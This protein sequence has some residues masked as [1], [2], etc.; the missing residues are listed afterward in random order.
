MKRAAVAAFA[1]LLLVGAGVCL[2]PD[3]ASETAE[4]QATADAHLPPKTPTI[5]RKPV[6]IPVAPV[7]ASASLSG[8]VHRLG[9]GVS[10]VTII[11]KSESGSVTTT[12]REGGAFAFEK[13]APGSYLFSAALGEEA[14]RVLGPLTIDPGE[15][16]TGVVLE[17]LPSATLVGTVVSAATREPVP[18]ARVVSGGVSVITPASGRFELK[19]VSVGEAWI[20]VS[21]NGFM[22]RTEWLTI[23]AA[24]RLS[25]M[26]ITL[27]P[28][29]T[30]RG[31][32]TRMGTPLAGVTVSAQSAVR[33]ATETGTPGSAV[34]DG[35][36][37]F[38]LHVPAGK[39]T[40]FASAP[41]EARVDGPTLTLGPGE[42]REGADIELGQ[43]LIAVGRITVDGRPASGAQVAAF[44]ARSGALH[45]TA[46]SDP[47]GEF[48]LAGLSPGSYLL[49]VHANG[50]DAQ[51]G[52]F[53]VS[54]SFDAPWLI[55]LRSEGVVSGSVS[56]PTAGVIVRIRGTEWV[57]PGAQTATDAQGRFQFNGVS[58]PVILQAEGEGGSAEARANPGD[59]VTLTL[60]QA[61]LRG[62]VTD[63][64]GRAVTDFSVRLRPLTGGASRTYAVLSPLGTFRVQTPPGSYEVTAFAPGLGGAQPVQGESVRGGSGSEVRL[65]LSSTTRFSVHVFDGRTQKPIAGAEAQVRGGGIAYS[66]SVFATLKTDGDGNFEVSSAPKSAGVLVSADGYQS[67]WFPVAAAA[68][69]NGAPLQI[70]LNAGSKPD[71]QQP[72]EGI[73]LSWQQ[74]PNAFVVGEVFPGSPAEGAGIRG[75]DVLTSIDGRPSAGMN[76][77]QVIAGIRGP[78]GTSVR[79]GFTRGGQPYE[80]VVRRRAI[81]L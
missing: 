35:E 73:G 33:D 54:G 70:A 12:S 36:G 62:V 9:Q 19:G 15:Q 53:E 50:V 7:L 32:V 38:E 59:D 25:G 31:L 80:V 47:A 78:A 4:T 20:E 2:W 6:V 58:G 13:L 51:R 23:D 42:L 16:K 67:R 71:W 44:E 56:P 18:N 17:L 28:A 60:E 14:S 22:P 24:R 30:V 1:L 72:Y 27:T 39:A 11:A 68:S 74:V 29:A 43:Q 21:A 66:A 63:E 5:A 45:G 3:D 34:S 65:S 48:Q 46:Y 55:E 37:H 26:E 40:L 41:G 64:Q 81:S 61:V 77:N 10:G 8:G 79:L 52:P 75:N 69:T 76:M 57:G 49:Q